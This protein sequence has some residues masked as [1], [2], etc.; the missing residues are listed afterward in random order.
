M[1]TFTAVSIEL[2]KGI[3]RG[4]KYILRTLEFAPSPTSKSMKNLPIYWPDMCFFIRGFVLTLRKI[5]IVPVKK[6]KQYPREDFITRKKLRKSKRNF[7]VKF[8]PLRQ[9]NIISA[10]SM[11]SFVSNQI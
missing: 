3:G 1:G 11:K 2:C 7:H 6:N 8:R 10:I 4:T 9:K 5:I